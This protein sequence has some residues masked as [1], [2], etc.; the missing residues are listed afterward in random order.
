ML[1]SHRYRFIFLKTRKTAGSSVELAFEPYARPEGWTPP[2]GDVTFATEQMVSEA[3][4]VGARSREPKMGA[5]YIDHMTARSLRLRLSR[6]VWNGYFKFCTI[7]NPWDK[8]VSFFHHAHKHLRDEPPRTLARRFRRWLQTGHYERV[9]DLPIAWIGGRPV[10]DGFIRYHRLEEDAAAVAEHLG[11]PE[12]LR[13]GGVHT[14]Y[15]D[16]DRMSYVDYYEDDTRELVAKSFAD[17]IAHFGWTFDN[18]VEIDVPQARPEP[19]FVSSLLARLGGQ[20]RP[21]AARNDPASGRQAALSASAER[22]SQ[23][24]E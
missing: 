6:R 5:D 3:G 12:P 16:K 11:I 18:S 1:V 23:T 7:R 4:I 9:K 15:R 10:T 2:E 14:Q 8:T 17:E 22:A 24:N 13:I 21:A 20:G 19:G